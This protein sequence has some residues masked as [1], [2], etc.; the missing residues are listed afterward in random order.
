MNKENNF[1]KLRQTVK[2]FESLLHSSADGIVITDP[3]QNIIFVNDTFCNFFSAPR[4][5]ML[6]TCIS[7]WIGRPGHRHKDVFREWNRL[8]TDVQKLGIAR[9]TEFLINTDAG[10][11][12][13]AV[14]ASLVKR[15]GAE[16]PGTIISIWRDITVRK[17]A[18]ENLLTAYGAL[19]S[20]C[21]V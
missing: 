2:F 20:C 12:H 15:I 11:R 10:T 3:A 7:V 17:Q 19:S 18:Q 16:E 6:E 14:N 4:Q 8:A 9:D 21:P 1:F 5:N 13:F